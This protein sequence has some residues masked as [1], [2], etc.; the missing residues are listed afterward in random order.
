MKI[1]VVSGS[2]LF[3]IQFWTRRGQ[4][5]PLTFRGVPPDPKEQLAPGIARPGCMG[6][7]ENTEIMRSKGAHSKLSVTGEVMVPEQPKERA[8]RCC[9]SQQGRFPQLWFRRRC[10]H[11]PIV[12]CLYVPP[13]VPVVD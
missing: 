6:G 11:W 7:C 2:R 1:G 4:A 12:R 5:L 10:S 8:T 3:V 9:G 13:E